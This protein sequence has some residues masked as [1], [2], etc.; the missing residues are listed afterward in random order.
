[1]S[2]S[3]FGWSLPPGCGA[4]P[5]ENDPDPIGA[6]EEYLKRENKITLEYQDILNGDAGD[7]MT[8]LIELAIDF[9][10][11]CGINEAKAGEA[12]FRYWIEGE[13]RKEMDEQGENIASVIRA[14]M[15]RILITLQNRPEAK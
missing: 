4:L 2:R 10:V 8:N 13:V 7:D 11:M 1:M 6:F 5:G 3:I 15:Q 14:S 9:G 12:E